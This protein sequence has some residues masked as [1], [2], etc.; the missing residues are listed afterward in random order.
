MIRKSSKI[1]QCDWI[2][3]E[4]SFPLKTFLLDWAYFQSSKWKI[5]TCRLA[6]EIRLW[7]CFKKGEEK[8]HCFFIL[9]VYNFTS[10]SLKRFFFVHGVWQDALQMMFVESNNFD[11]LKTLIQGFFEDTQHA[12]QEITSKSDGFITVNHAIEQLSFLSSWINNKFENLGKWGSDPEK[13]Y[14][15]VTGPKGKLEFNLLLS[16]ASQT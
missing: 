3:T 4:N 12:I 14:F 1:F 16:P 8:P 15:W 2:W 11:G 13:Q 7:A 5:C 9:L 6:L 10:C